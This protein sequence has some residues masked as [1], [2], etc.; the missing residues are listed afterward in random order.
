MPHRLLRTFFGNQGCFGV[1]RP[2]RFRN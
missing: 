1:Q 2:V